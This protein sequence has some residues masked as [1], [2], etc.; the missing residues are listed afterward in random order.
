LTIELHEL[1]LY[2]AE[3]YGFSLYDSM[4]VSAALQSDCIILYS[5]DMLHGQEIEAKLVISNPFMDKG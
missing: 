4:I 2:I 5:E 3:K 1:G